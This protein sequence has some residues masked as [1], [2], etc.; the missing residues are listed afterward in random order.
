MT[1]HTSLLIGA[2]SLIGRF[3]LI[4]SIILTSLSGVMLAQDYEGKKIS[5]VSIRYVGSKTV[6]E[7]RLRNLMVTKAGTVYRAENLDND[8]KTLFESGLIDDLK[9]LAEAAGEGVRVIAQVQTRPAINGVG[10]VGNTIF[11]EQKLAKETK[12]KSG[13]TM[14]DAEILEARQNLEKYYQGHGYPDVI[15]SH[16][17]QE[18]GQQ[19]LAD[20]IFVIDEGAKNEVRDIRFEGN[21]VFTSAEL[22]KEMKTKEKGWFSWLTKSGRFESTTLD[23]D[24]DAVLDYY[25]SRGYLRVSSPGVRRDPVKDGRVDLVIEIS[26][27]DKYSVSGISFGEMSVFK[28]EELYP[29]MT[30]NGGD[31]YSSTKMREDIKTIR[32]FYGSRGYAD[33]VVSPDIKDAGPNQVSI[34]YQITEG[35]RYRVGRVNI[36]GNSKT[37]DKV[38]RRE[39]PLNPG[40]WFNTVE[41]ETTKARLKN[42]QYFSDVQ[43]NGSPA[44]NGYRDINV[45]VEERNTG[46]VGVGVGFS[47]IDNVVGFLTLEQTNFDITNPWNFTGGGQRFGMNLRAGSERSEFTLS[48]VEP[49]FMDR[50]LSLGGELFYRQSSYFSDEYDQTNVGASVFLRKPLSEKSSIKLAYSLENITVD[51]DSGA[52][53]VFQDEDGDFVRSALTLSYLYDSRDSTITPR[54]GEKLDVSFAFAGLGGDVETITLSTQGSKYWNLKWDTILSLSGE[55][56]FVDSINGDVPIFERMFLGGGRTLRGF[57]FRDIG[58]DRDGPLGEV[59]GG[60]SLA[61][62]NTEY[63]VPIVETIRAAVFYDM[64]FVNSGSW[65][66][67]PQD[68]YSDVGFGIRIQLPI[69]PVPIALDYAVPVS[70]PDSAA[71][72]GGQFNFYM[73]YEY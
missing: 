49:W 36:Q 35:S 20:L 58:G 64:G 52:S 28:S 13:G 71:D 32:S 27:G 47:S 67:G 63:T 37:Q 70:S 22:K 48:L 51:V 53:A 2:K 33:A 40:D 18:T 25:R 19:G 57:E 72:Q 44:G 16:R 8:I 4:T 60:Q 54:K 21:S 43:A 45:L 50:K 56:A 31:A 46:S 24:L 1:A 7:A 73:S 11:S 61:F 34:K 15:I 5:E 6:D 65:D 17:T 9:F 55:V 38:I 42:L 12:L 3:S 69:S 23:E 10:F 59:L 26:E 41:L 29:S 66:I 62:L 14:S 68:V 30:L 39:L